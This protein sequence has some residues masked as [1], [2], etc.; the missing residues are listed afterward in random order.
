M[1]EVS[2]YFLVKS[3]VNQKYR[4]KNLNYRRIYFLFKVL[5][6]IHFCIILT[7]TNDILK[8]HQ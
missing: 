6:Q 8:S 4:L 1:L 3:N 7:H 2:E 5:Y